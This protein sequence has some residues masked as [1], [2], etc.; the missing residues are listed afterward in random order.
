MSPMVLN[1]VADQ[2]FLSSEHT[3][4]FADSPLY[5]AIVVTIRVRFDGRGNT[6]PRLKVF[7]NSLD[8]HINGGKEG[9]E[10]WED[11]DTLWVPAVLC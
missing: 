6:T 1:D 8:P 3:A 11:E 2:M 9:R 5:L 7:W 4:F 10:L